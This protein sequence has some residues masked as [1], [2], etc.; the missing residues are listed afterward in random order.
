MGSRKSRFLKGLSAQQQRASMVHRISTA[1][2]GELTHQPSFPVSSSSDIAATV[3][4]CQSILWK[5]NYLADLARADYVPLAFWLA[6]S[7]RPRVL[8]EL[9]AGAAVSYFAFCQVIERLNFSSRC[10]AVDDWSRHASSGNDSLAKV[11]AYSALHYEP[12]STILEIDPW[13]SSSSFSEKSIDL[14][15]ING[16]ESFD[17]SA[18]DLAS[19]LPKLSDRALLLVHGTSPSTS[20][21]DIQ[22]LVSRLK[23]HYSS[24]DFLHGEGLTIFEMERSCPDQ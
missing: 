18:F 22:S 13:R 6:E 14:L 4:A 11:E 10:F 12:F 9:G 15:Q 3:L 2:D 23:E 7:H 24:F 19:W 16:K 8:V 20:N 5:P 17:T 21:P 1:D